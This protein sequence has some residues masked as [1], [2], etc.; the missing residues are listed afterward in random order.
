MKLPFEW[1]QPG[2]VKE[3]DAVVLTT[4]TIETLVALMA[5]AMIALVRDTAHTEEVTDER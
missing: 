2:D 3:V 1:H 4:K 5:S